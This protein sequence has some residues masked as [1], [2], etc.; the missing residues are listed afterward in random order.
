MD[1][2]QNQ[3]ELESV[4]KTLDSINALRLSGPLTD[5]VSEVYDSLCDREAEL[6]HLLAAPA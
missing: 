1:R 5:Q 3:L 4:R 2:A 6:L